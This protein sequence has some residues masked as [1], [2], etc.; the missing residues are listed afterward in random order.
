VDRHAQERQLEDRWRPS[1]QQQR[2]RTQHWHQPDPLLWNNNINNNNEE[3]AK[4]K[5]ESQLKTRQSTKGHC[6]I[7]YIYNHN[8]KA[9]HPAA[10]R[11]PFD[12][13]RVASAGVHPAIPSKKFQFHVMSEGWN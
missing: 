3:A 1:K 12:R 8:P 2:R 4:I 5:K 13:N 7:A 10:K 6:N 11:D 9:Y